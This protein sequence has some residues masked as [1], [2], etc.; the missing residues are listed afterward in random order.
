MSRSDLKVAAGRLTITWD[1]LIDAREVAYVIQRAGLDDKGHVRDH[2]FYDDG[3]AMLEAI[4]AYEQQREEAL[5]D[6]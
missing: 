4:D 5:E 3:T 6:W 1:D 2:G